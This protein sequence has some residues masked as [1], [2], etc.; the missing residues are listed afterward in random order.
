MKAS[1]AGA[2]VGRGRRAVRWAHG[3]EAAFGDVQHGAEPRKCHEKQ[4]KNMKKKYEKLWKNHGKNAS[5]A[6]APGVQGL[7][8]LLCPV[9]LLERLATLR[10]R[11]DVDLPT[12]VLAAVLQVLHVAHLHGPLLVEMKDESRIAKVDHL[13]GT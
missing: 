10:R 7:P 1:R 9:G 4:L 12:D 2:H 3:V 11:G 8:L 5:K 6:A 13:V